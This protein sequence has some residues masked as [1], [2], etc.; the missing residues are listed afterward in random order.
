[1]L[2]E[3]VVLLKS[4]I[5]WSKYFTSKSKLSIMNNLVAF[6]L[7]QNACLGERGHSLLGNWTSAKLSKRSGY[8][9]S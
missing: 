9:R 2:H 7:I 1:M 5:H 3:C 8:K 4:V 6:I